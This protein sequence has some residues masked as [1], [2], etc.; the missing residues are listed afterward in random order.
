MKKWLAVASVVCNLILL[1]ILLWMRAAL[2]N[3]LREVSRAAMRGD[4]RH[5]RLHAA[6]L[7]AL[8]SADPAEAS[9]MADVLRMIVAAGDLNIEARRRAGLGE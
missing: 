8:E 7:A 2:H 4:E 5:V 9:K 6:S 1:A 3:E